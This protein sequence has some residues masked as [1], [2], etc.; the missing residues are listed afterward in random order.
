[1]LNDETFEEK[2]SLTLTR[3]NVW[4]FLST[5]VVVLVLL[6]ASAIIYTPLKYAIPGFGDYNYRSQI[7]GLTFKTDSLSEAMEARKMWL[8]N[9]SEVVSGKIDSA[10]SAKAAMQVR[11]STVKE[12]NVEG[13]SDE[14][15]K[16][17]K[18]IEQEESYSLSYKGEKGAGALNLN[19]LHFFLPV[20]GFVTEEFDPAREHYGVDVAAP[21]DASVKAALDGTVLY[22]GWSLETGY[23][24][25]I[26]H[27]DNLVTIYKHNSKLFK[28]AGNAVKAGEVI[29]TVGST[30]ELSSGP[31]L[32]FELWHKGGA[33]NPRD[34]L[35]LG[36]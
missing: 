16:L 1:M 32:H 13:P 23:A 4:V 24:I 30:G 3:L 9:I 15:L 18:D 7:V 35:V 10:A 31:H 14:E 27:A 25:A 8:D 6:T 29:A 36:K 5:L 2:F 26:Q 11:P 21:R 33:L 28:S 20:E 19:Q 22:A 17:R 12:K 34:Y